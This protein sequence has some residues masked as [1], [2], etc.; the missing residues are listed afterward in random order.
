MA[1]DGLVIAGQAVKLSLLAVNRGA[2]DVNVTSVTIA[3]F[4]APANCAAPVTLRPLAKPLRNLTCA[5]GVV[6]VVAIRFATKG[7]R[8]VG[9]AISLTLVL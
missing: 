3:G 1:D 6:S 9:I 4:D 7:F 2:T 8:F 5:S